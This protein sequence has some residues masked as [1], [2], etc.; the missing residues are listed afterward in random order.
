MLW[1]PSHRSCRLVERPYG[2]QI[3]VEYCPDSANGKR[4]ERLST[5]RR[6]HK[7]D[8]KAIRRVHVHHRAEI[9]SPESVLRKIPI[10][11]HGIEGFVLH[12]CVPGKAVTKRGT[13]SPF[14]MIQTLTTV[15]I[16]P[17]GPRRSA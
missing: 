16:L 8:F 10:E 14:S 6:V 13:S 2:D 11:D 3:R 4:H 1:N 5:T 15:A 17:D 12:Y 7:L 9:A